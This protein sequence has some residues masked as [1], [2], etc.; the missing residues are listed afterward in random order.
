MDNEIFF[1][2]LVGDGLPEDWRGTVVVRV[3]PD[4]DLFEALKAGAAG[5]LLKEASIEEVADAVRAVAR[6]ERLLSPAMTAKL[7]GGFTE[8]A[9]QADTRPV[10]PV[11]PASVGT[12]TDRERQALSGIARGLSNQ[13]IADELGIAQNTV[14]NHVRGVLEKLGVSSRT[15]AALYAAREGLTGPG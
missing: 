12:L 6:G 14:K 4:A 5:Y 1:V 9:R 10:A 7:L 3:Q 15:E 8:L 11:A 13:A 2:D